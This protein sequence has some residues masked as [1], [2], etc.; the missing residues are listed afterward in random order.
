LPEER[1]LEKKKAELAVLEKSLAQHEL[2]LATLR[3]QLRDFEL[4]YLEV[5]G[6]RFAELDELEAEIAEIAARLR[7]DAPEI[8][9]RARQARSKAEESA[10]TTQLAPDARSAGGF[11]PSSQLREIYRAAAKEIHPDLASDE[12]ERALRQRVMADVNR[13]YEQQ[14][15]AAIKA[16]LL[17][18]AGRPDAIK[19]EGPLPELG[20]IIRT[21]DRV[22]KRLAE[23][24]KEMTDIEATTL[25]R[26]WK[27]ADRATRE[28]R[29]LLAELAADVGKRIRAARAQADAARAS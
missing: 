15:E 18:W 14:D 20:R 19:G 24:R 8:Q 6:R 1:E 22:E 29:D 27:Q 3:A 9:E 28:N 11:A 12:D 25:H 5:V 21:I 10:S 17:D 2:D 7:P 4:R 26:L 23:I 16:I 13:A